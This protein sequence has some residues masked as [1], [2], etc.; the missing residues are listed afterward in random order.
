MKIGTV[1]FATKRGLGYLAKS[2]YNHGIITDVAYI[3]HGSIETQT[4]WYPDG[5]LSGASSRSLSQDEAIRAMIRNV[6][7]MLYFE[8]PFDWKLFDY[9]RSVGTKS[10]LMTMYECTPAVL[11]YNPDLYLCPSLLDL[12][13]FPREHSIFLPIP[14]DL[15][16]TKWR[17]RER[18]KVYVH[19]GGYLGL[20]MRE[21][22]DKVI[23]AMQYVKSP[24]KLIVRCQKSVGPTHERMAAKDSRIEYQCG[25][26]QHGSLYETGDVAVGAQI[27]NGCS[28][29]LQE[30][31]ASGL[32]VMNTRRFPMTT[33]LPNSP[34]IPPRRIIKG[35]AAR[36]FKTIEI[37]QVSPEDI[38]AKMDEF[39]GSDISSYSRAGKIWAEEN[40]WEVLGPKYL[41][42]FTELL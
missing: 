20:Q 2:F 34:L 14:V 32:C 5:Y 36:G 30:A 19:N 25:I 4:D 21:G 28:L 7:W 17:L 9:A 39:Y 12:D 16:R 6:D 26:A 15:E 3:R 35:T 27:W 41:Q 38:A 11:P 18:A 1:C 22:T 42:V 33:W 37:S 23:E 13:Y 31:Y 40:S 8:T 24:L 29:P 10:A